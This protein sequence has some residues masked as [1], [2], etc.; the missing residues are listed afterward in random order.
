[1]FGSVV[2]PTVFHFEV[3][4]AYSAISMRCALDFASQP[5]IIADL[6]QVKFGYR[7]MWS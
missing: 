2:Q 3:T 1:M 4:I 7:I 5:T 6:G